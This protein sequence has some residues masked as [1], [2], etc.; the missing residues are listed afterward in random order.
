MVKRLAILLGCSVF[1]I[2]GVTVKRGPGG[3]GGGGGGGSATRLCN[4]SVESATDSDDIMC[5]EATSDYTLV[6]LT[7]FGTGAPSAHDVTV[8]ECNSSGGVCTT[9]TGLSVT[10]TGGAADEEFDDD[11]TG[12]DET[13]TSGNWFVIAT[14]GEPSTPAAWMHCQLEYT[15]G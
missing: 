12:G 4:T 9:A 2:A 14:D 3:S 6:S 7:C 8:F 1:L 11:F 5:G 13:I 10:I 15:E